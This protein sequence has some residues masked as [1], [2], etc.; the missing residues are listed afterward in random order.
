MTWRRRLGDL[1]VVPAPDFFSLALSGRRGSESRCGVQF[2]VRL[3]FFSGTVFDTN[4]L[5]GK[6]FLRWIVFCWP[7]LFRKKFHW[8]QV[9]TNQV[10]L[11]FELNSVNPKKR[12]KPVPRQNAGFTRLS[13]ELLPRR[14]PEHVRREE[15]EIDGLVRLLTDGSFSLIMSPEI[16]VWTLLTL[17]D[18]WYPSSW[19]L[20]EAEESDQLISFDT[21]S[22]R[23]CR[24]ESLKESRNPH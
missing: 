22:L 23:I 15:S 8:M 6:E 2:Y 21:S 3:E 12:V 13:V 7:D 11:E 14:W 1:H 24:T 17:S 9:L 16:C 4:V 10:K 18:G 5:L 19:R 20:I